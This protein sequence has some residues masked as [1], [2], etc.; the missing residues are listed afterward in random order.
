MC[1]CVCAVWKQGKNEDQIGWEMILKDERKD[2]LDQDKERSSIISELPRGWQYTCQHFADDI[3]LV[4]KTTP[5][6]LP[7]LVP[8]NR[9]HR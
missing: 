4:G 8:L 3:L 7:G 9:S 1:V 5:T 6:A 2:D